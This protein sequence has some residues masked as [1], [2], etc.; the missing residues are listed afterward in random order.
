MS[1][2]NL[3]LYIGIYLNGEL[4][5]RERERERERETRACPSIGA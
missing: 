3:S 4:I 5:E 1:R 2:F